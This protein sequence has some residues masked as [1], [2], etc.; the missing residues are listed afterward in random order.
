M[1]SLV[2]NTATG[3]AVLDGQTLT[4]SQIASTSGNR[5]STENNFSFAVNTGT[6]ATVTNFTNTPLSV[7]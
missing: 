3:T 4:G 1:I 6:A 5:V 7:A 2:G